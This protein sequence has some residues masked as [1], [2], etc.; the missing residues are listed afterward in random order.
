MVRRKDGVTCTATAKSTGNRCGN[1]P[2]PGGQVCK[3]HGGKAPQVLAASA[4]NILE[5]LV[6]PA[7]TKMREILEDVSTPPAVRLA[8]VRDVLDRT[9]FKPVE[10]M[11]I[12]FEQAESRLDQEFEELVKQ[13]DEM[14]AEQK[15]DDEAHT[16]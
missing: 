10:Q 11:A 9:G 6:G 7:L 2:L 16:D 12:T 8:A 4:R 14:E 1:P 13:F 15:A 5:S 3:S